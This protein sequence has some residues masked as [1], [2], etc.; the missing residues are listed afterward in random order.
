MSRWLL[1]FL[2]LWPVAAFAETAEEVAKRLGAPATHASE[3]AADPC[4]A[5]GPAPNPRAESLCAWQFQAAIEAQKYNAA[6]HRYN[7]R[8]YERHQF[9]T[10]AAAVMVYVLTTSG[11]VFAGLQFFGFGA[12]RRKGEADPTATT[13]KFGGMAEISSP[14]LGLVV[15]T[16]SLG[17]F[18]LY[19]TQVYTIRETAPA[20]ARP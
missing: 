4:L 6:V 5:L 14:V 11:L 10:E 19:L 13:F 8:M 3:A 12:R 9:W 7:A 20:V 17:F 16:I 2:L 18:Y 15:L 1:L